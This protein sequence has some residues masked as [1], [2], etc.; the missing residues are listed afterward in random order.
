[1][2]YDFNRFSPQSFERF[3]QS[4][5]TKEIG[6]G[7]SIFGAGPDGAREASFHGPLP[8]STHGAPWNG[9]VVAQAK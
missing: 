6:P 3:A 9:Y 8:I 4:L 1:M 7:V 5:V 2:P